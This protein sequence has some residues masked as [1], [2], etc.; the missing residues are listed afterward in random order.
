MS[1]SHDDLSEAV[2]FRL[3]VYM[4]ACIR[5]SLRVWLIKWIKE[6]VCFVIMCNKFWEK[7]WPQGCEQIECEHRIVGFLLMV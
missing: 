6:R 4:W 5:V 1:K 3:Y 7:Q 2:G